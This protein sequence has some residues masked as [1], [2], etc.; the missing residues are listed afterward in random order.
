VP[1]FVGRAVHAFET[2]DSTQS[3]LARLAQ[4]GAPEGTVVTAA[5]QTAG[6]GRHGHQWWDAPGAALLCSILLRPPVPVS[7]A[8]QLSLV[9]GLAVAEA[10]DE[11]AG[12]AARIRW[13]ND[14]L[15]DGR[16]VSGILPD[17]VSG[18]DGGVAYVLLGI[19]VNVNQDVFPAD[20]AALAT[21]L[22]LLT[23]QRRDV[24]DLLRPLMSALERRYGTWLDTGFASL[25]DDWRRRSS[26]V[27]QR[28]AAPSGAEGVA[29]DVD[30]DGALLVD[31]GHGRVAR[32]VAASS[33]RGVVGDHAPG[34]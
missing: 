2:V 11:A 24:G 32:L 8:P 12:V 15:I 28:M 26:T 29:I 23:G 31:A 21:S 9:A 7:R 6:R 27:G 16:K 5:H 25:R 17:A 30:D 33:G 10:L 18:A 13:P 3:V 34:P 4:G 14:V 22:Y 19:G 1:P 20:L